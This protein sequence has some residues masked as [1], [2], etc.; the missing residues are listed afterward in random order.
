MVSAIKSDFI[1]SIIEHSFSFEAK[2][3]L[4]KNLSNSIP[5]KN[6]AEE[7][8]L[9]TIDRDPQSQKNLPY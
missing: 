3:F 1:F 4:I 2:I 9:L 5:E 6:A 7:G 8:A